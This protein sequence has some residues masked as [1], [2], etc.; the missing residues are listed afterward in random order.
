M[1]TAIDLGVVISADSHVMEPH[2]LWSNA[3]SARFGDKAP[4]FPP[5]QVGQGLQAH[6]GGWD[7][8]E[9]I[10]E[11]R[12]DGVSAEIL[13]PTL[14]L[15]LFAIEDAA[16]QEAVF[17]TYNDWL[18]NYCQAA[19]DRL[20]GVALIA[21]YDIEHAVAELRRCRNMGLRGA[22]IW[23]S[24]PKDLP[25][26]SEHY[27][28]LWAALEELQMPLSMHILTG[29]S[30]H[31][32]PVK[33]GSPAD[34]RGRTN[35]KLLDSAN[36]VFDFI[37]FGIFDRYPG[38]KLVSV[39]NE[40]GW[41]PFLIQQW[42]YY[43]RRFRNSDP[44]PIAFE[45]H[46]YAE[47]NVFATFFNDAVGGHNLSWWGQDNCMWSNDYPHPNSSWPHS[48]EIIDRDL[49]GLPEDVLAKLVRENVCRLYNMK[50]PLPAAE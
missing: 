9:R 27:E 46:V 15:P 26:E 40:I 11:M 21:C 14:G 24:P 18:I 7:P 4:S 33:R 29:F 47:R 38:L 12:A 5:H 8:A 32:G 28:P 17:A 2:D 23:L 35:L 36:A 16:L 39:E 3:L 1:A 42:D 41:L 13:Y 37:H 44:L 49:G 25:F 6:A 50:P 43:F 31:T 20:L 10:K 22:E 30:Y 19:P 45:P 34:L 48:R